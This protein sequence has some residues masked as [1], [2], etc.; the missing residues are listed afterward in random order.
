MRQ[1][2]S[3]EI[4]QIGGGDRTSSFNECMGNNWWAD[5]SKG[6]I[7]GA[8]GGAMF[9]PGAVLGGIGGAMAGSTAAFGYCVFYII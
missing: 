7:G 5:T 1:L 4:A 3:M 9:G 8:I 2:N 6:A